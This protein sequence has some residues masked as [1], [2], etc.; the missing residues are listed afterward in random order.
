MPFKDFINADPLYKRLVD[1]GDRME[2]KM[3]RALYC[4]GKAELF[5]SRLHWLQWLHGLEMGRLRE[6]R[7][8]YDASRVV[9]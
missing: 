9:A 2:A 3:D 6:L 7:V 5:R 4:R 1:L 8:Q